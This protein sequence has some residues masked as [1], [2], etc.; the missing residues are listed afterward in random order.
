MKPF[1]PAPRSLERDPPGSQRRCARFKRCTPACGAK[2]SRR[3]FKRKG[4]YRP[5]FNRLMSLLSVPLSRSL[6]ISSR[7]LMPMS[8]HG[9]T[10]KTLSSQSQRHSL[11]GSTTTR[12]ITGT[13]HTQDVAPTTPAAATSPYATAGSPPLP[14]VSP[15]PLSFRLPIHLP[16]PGRSPNPQ[17]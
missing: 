5:E 15:P 6:F 1:L 10:R 11:V 8:L 4:A 14:P 2:T 17:T 3:S 12:G 7:P 13:S 16:A 9:E